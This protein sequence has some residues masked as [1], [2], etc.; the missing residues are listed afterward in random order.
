M[1]INTRLKS[2]LV[3]TQLPLGTDVGALSCF[4]DTLIAG[5]SGLAKQGATKKDLTKAVD[6][7]MQSWPS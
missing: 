5:L 2:T 6:V 3:D 7:G 1:A 4:Y